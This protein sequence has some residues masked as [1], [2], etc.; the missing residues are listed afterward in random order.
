[1]ANRARAPFPATPAPSFD[2]E[3]LG[4]DGDPQ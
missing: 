3:L 2:V 4:I 1:M